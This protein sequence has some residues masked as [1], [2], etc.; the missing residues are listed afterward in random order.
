MSTFGINACYVSSRTAVVSRAKERA[1]HERGIAR[2]R[3][4]IVVVVGLILAVG[5]NAFLDKHDDAMRPSLD[6][7]VA[8]E[9][10]E[11]N[12]RRQATDAVIA[13][14]KVITFTTT[15]SAR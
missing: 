1:A 11:L 12:A 13:G 7:L 8:Q 14:D 2:R 5:F 6:K 4:V 9:A 15:N 10:K 3:C